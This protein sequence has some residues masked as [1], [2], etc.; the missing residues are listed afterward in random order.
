MMQQKIF[1]S[2]LIFFLSISL[3]FAQE[4][5]KELVQWMSFDKAVEAAKKDTNK[6]MLID[7]Y[8][9]W[10]T[11]CEMMSERTLNHPKVAKIINEKF[12]PVKFNA[13]GNAKIQF[14]GQL[15]ENKG[16]QEELSRS[17]NAVHPF[18]YF[19]AQTNRGIAYPTISFL[20]YDGK[21]KHPVQGVI[22]AQDF[23]LLLHYVSG[24]YYQKNIDFQDFKVKYKDQIDF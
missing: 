11:P 16:Y 7:I 1:S 6:M 17:R 13:E 5:K 9:V 4:K 14:L 20:S 24:K 8:T 12:Y 19:I 23:A 21:E 22:P 15:Y 10:C 3:S 18:T 2:I